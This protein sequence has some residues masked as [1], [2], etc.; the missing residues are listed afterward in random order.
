[1]SIVTQLE[2]YNEEISMFNF[3]T[4]SILGLSFGCKNRSLD[5]KE[6]YIVNKVEK[7]VKLIQNEKAKLLKLKYKI[8]KI[9]KN[10]I[11]KKEEFQKKC[12]KLD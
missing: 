4:I 8:F 2:E 11:P 7:E 9:L 12:K 1:M 5:S 10:K 3:I 6:R